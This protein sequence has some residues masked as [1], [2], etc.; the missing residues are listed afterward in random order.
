MVHSG[1]DCL[2]LAKE[3]ELE[4]TRERVA[5]RGPVQFSLNS[6]KHEAQMAHRFSDERLSMVMGCL[7]G[8]C[9]VKGDDELWCHR[10]C[11]RRLHPLKCGQVSVARAKLGALVC[12]EC[13]VGDMGKWS[14]APPEALVL[15]KSAC[16]SMLVELASGAEGTARNLA[17]FERL[18]REWL[19]F[20]SAD[21]TDGASTLIEPRYS[22]ESF[23]SFLNWLPFEAGRARSFV[24]IVRAAGM[25]L[26]KMELKNHTKEPRVKSTIKE[27]TDSLGLEPDPCIL[28]S[29]RIIRVTIDRTLP[30][31]CGNFISLLIRSLALLSLELGT[32]LRVGEATGA[33]EGHGVVAN[34]IYIATV[35]KGHQFEGELIVAIK[36]TD[37]KTGFGR[38]CAMFGTTHGELAITNA[39][40]MMDLWRDQGLTINS[41]IRDG[42][43][44][45]GPDYWVLRLS[46]LG[47][48]DQDVEDVKRFILACAIPAVAEQANAVVSRIK[49]LRIAKGT[50]EEK[51]TVNLIGG[52]REGLVL[53]HAIAWAEGSRWRSFFRVV[54]GPL[55]RAFHGKLLTHRPLQPGSTYSHLSQAVVDAYHLGKESGVEDTELDLMGSDPDKPKVGNHWARR[56]G[57]KEAR[58]FRHVTGVSE[59]DID[60]QF[61]WNQKRRQ[62]SQQIHYSGR[63]E[64]LQKAKC[65]MML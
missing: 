5:A 19:A 65:T 33:G 59:D 17:E 55:I 57:D 25:A 9:G 37:S 63:T 48:N 18:E 31:R 30:E 3:A 29:R 24:T 49:Q 14:G 4:R 10:G 20:M 46:L 64:L 60:D 12:V 15:R 1:G 61:G 8:V 56:K 13:R 47:M 11:G 22:E 2:R 42:M 6:A 62:Q 50:H 38:E 44:C 45:V 54:D 35:P 27:I 43:R 7:N 23:I 21:L 52:P 34:N 53:R 36:L 40:Y 51:Q 26:A 39:K 41:F 32:G 58:D 16:R 28:P